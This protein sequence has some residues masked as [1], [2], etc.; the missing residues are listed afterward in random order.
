M[1][2]VV[3]LGL[4][5]L[6]L[7]AVQF[8]SGKTVD[9]VIEKHIQSIG[10]FDKAYK[11]ESIYMEGVIKTSTN[12][13]FVK[14]VKQKNQYSDELISFNTQCQITDAENG[15]VA[16]QYLDTYSKSLSDTI[17]ALLTEPEVSAALLT[18][19]GPGH[20]PALLGKDVVDDKTCYKIR[21]NLKGGSQVNYWF[22][23]TG[24]Q[25]IQ[26]LIVNSN[27][28]TFNEKPV[29]TLYNNYQQIQ[30]CPMAH[31]I[32]ISNGDLNDPIK[33]FFSRIEIDQYPD[34][35][36]LKHNNQS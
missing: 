1:K 19:S 10:G 9:E 3:L 35:N 26:V 17:A 36:F 18:Y 33:I 15:I 2:N 14:I 25:L 4:L 27:S 16:S 13:N 7:V 6:L 24:F 5:V 11:I 21:L 30:G 28:R 32:E 23:S 31:N 22:T 8:A 12:L 34:L 20:H 29:Q